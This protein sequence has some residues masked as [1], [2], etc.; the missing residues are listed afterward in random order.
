MIVV[1]TDILIDVARENSNAITCLQQIEQQ[2][3]IV[4]S[5]VTQMVLRCTPPVTIC[6]YQL[7]AG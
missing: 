2:S 7:K 4:I 6:G 1:D 3:S 5:S